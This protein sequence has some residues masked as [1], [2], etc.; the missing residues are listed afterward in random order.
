MR[1]PPVTGR[2]NRRHRRGSDVDAIQVLALWLHT[3]AFVIAWGYYGILARIVLPALERSL[4]L[5]AQAST[6]LAIERRALPFL[7]MTLVLFVVTGT[8]LLVIDPQYAGL[9]NVFASTWTRLMLVK[10][11]LVVGMVVLVVLVDWMIRQLRH[12]DGDDL[13]AS[14]LRLVALAADGV[15]GDGALIALVTVAAQATAQATA[16][17]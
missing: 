15:T 14:D 1:A 17:V 8:Y 10:H 4:D 2:P 13:R 6:L 7:G 5:P 16:Q 9:G 12:R 3:I 11:T